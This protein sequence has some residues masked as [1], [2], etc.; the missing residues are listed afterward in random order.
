ML[1]DGAYEAEL[2]VIRGDIKAKGVEFLQQVV[3][4]IDETEVLVAQPAAAAFIHVAEVMAR[5]SYL[6]C[7]GLVQSTQ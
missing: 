4:L 2:P 7:R 5:Q 1:R 6:S 3:E